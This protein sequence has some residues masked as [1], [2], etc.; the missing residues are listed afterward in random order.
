MENLAVEWD[1]TSPV[2]AH[3]ITTT[4]S[5]S[6]QHLVLGTWY[7]I[8]ERHRNCLSLAA[9]QGVFEGEAPPYPS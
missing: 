9:W 5:T 3:T 7:A 1:L 2:R 8:A 4:T 6:S